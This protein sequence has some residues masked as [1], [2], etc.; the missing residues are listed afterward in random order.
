MTVGTDE[1]VM[2]LIC[3]SCINTN[4][5]SSIE[6]VHECKWSLK[7]TDRWVRRDNLNPPQLYLKCF[8]ILLFIIVAECISSLFSSV[9]FSGLQATIERD[10]AFEN[11]PLHNWIWSVFV[12]WIES[13]TRRDFHRQTCTTNLHLYTV[14]TFHHRM[15]GCVFVFVCV[16]Q[17]FVVRGQHTGL[18]DTLYKVMWWAN[19]IPGSVK[20][21]LWFLSKRSRLNGIYFWNNKS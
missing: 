18:H 1:N 12:C 14:Y 8:S 9:L 16:I 6:R 5:C 7:H 10:E 17:V 3:V 2:I 20:H 13:E 15:M 21:G 4:I 19:S 11:I